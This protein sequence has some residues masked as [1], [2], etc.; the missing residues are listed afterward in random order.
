MLQKAI[1][2]FLFFS[3]ILIILAFSCTGI[4]RRIIL[5]SIPEVIHPASTP[6]TIS[7]TEKSYDK[8]FNRVSSTGSLVCISTG[9]LSLSGVYLKKSLRRMI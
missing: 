5:Q 7:I 3:T 9:S 6:K 2:I 4:N 1:E 8:V